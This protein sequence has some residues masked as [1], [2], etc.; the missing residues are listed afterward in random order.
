MAASFSRSITWSPAGMTGRGM[1]ETDMSA[2]ADGVV[3]IESP[4]GMRC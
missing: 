2:D 1:K 4:R 3:Q